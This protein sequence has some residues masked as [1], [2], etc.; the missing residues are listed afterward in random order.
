[1]LGAYYFRCSGL[2]R[3]AS[4]DFL[5][6]FSILYPLTFFYASLRQKKLI[7]GFLLIIFWVIA[8]MIPEWTWYLVSTWTYW[9]YE[10]S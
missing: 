6:F 2:G 5:I 9:D 4:F 8:Y 7:F 10:S 3:Q 1:M